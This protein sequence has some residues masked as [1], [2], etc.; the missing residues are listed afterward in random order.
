MNALLAIV[1][2]LAS[3]GADDRLQL[4]RKLEASGQHTAAIVEFQKVLENN[5]NQA[6]LW[7][8]LAQTRLAAGQTQPAIGDFSRA[9]RLDPTGRAVS[10]KPP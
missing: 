1:A 9:V 7:T 6:A 4:A 2:L 3:A 10:P 8:E 5:P